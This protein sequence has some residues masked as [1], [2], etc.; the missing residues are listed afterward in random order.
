MLTVAEALSLMTAAVRPMTH[1][2]TVPTLA[3]NGRVLA[4]AQAST[5][6]A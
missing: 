3:A 4:T 6:V 2:E 5:T 1:S